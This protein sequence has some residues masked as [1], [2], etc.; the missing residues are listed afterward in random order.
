MDPYT[1]SIGRTPSE[2][3]QLDSLIPTETCGF[4]G[5][6]HRE[7]SMISYDKEYRI[8]RSCAANDDGR[9]YG[10]VVTRMGD[11]FLRVNYFETFLQA[12]DYALYWRGLVIND[13]GDVLHDFETLP[14]EEVKEPVA[15]FI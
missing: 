10:A 1:L 12:F 8:C 14:F 3:E 15:M 6:R 11:C 2:Q 7:E 13:K 5:L 9:E 4:C